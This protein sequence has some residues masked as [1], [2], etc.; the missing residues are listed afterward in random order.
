MSRN[1][2]HRKECPCQ[3]C[4]P[5]KRHEACHDHCREYKDWAQPFAEAREQRVI[6]SQVRDAL[7]TRVQDF[8]DRKAMER[9]RGRKC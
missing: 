7:K 3:G 1:Y 9:K 4:T 8:V 2:N 5:P 6:Y